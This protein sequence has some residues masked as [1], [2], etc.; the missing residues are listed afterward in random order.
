[1]TAPS[2]SAFS[3]WPEG[4]RGGHRATSDKISEVVRRRNSPSE[5]MLKSS[6]KSEVN[7]PEVPG[8]P[9]SMEAIS[10]GRV[11]AWLRGSQASRADPTRR[12]DCRGGH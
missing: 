8:A 5:K 7:K 6:E 9:T 10:Q 12:P 4:Y 2:V 11:G 1:M 3:R